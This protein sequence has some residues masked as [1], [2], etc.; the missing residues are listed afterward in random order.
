MSQSQQK[1][2]R[3]AL[4]RAFGPEVTGVVSEQQRNIAAL[5]AAVAS[6]G[7]RVKTLEDRIAADAG[8]RVIPFDSFFGTGK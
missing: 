7:Q 3:R 8:P 5:A 4:R 6:L 2:T 1:A